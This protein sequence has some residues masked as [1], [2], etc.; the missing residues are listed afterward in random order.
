[1]VNLDESRLLESIRA[2]NAVRLE[3]EIVELAERYGR[4]LTPQ[5][6]QPWELLEAPRFDLLAEARQQH[7]EACFACAVTFNHQPALATLAA[8]AAAEAAQWEPAKM[9]PVAV[10][11][12]AAAAGAPVP[13]KRRSFR[14]ILRVPLWA[15]KRA[16]SRPAKPQP[17]RKATPAVD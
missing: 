17:A 3:P 5:C 16:F 8:Q 9:S 7:V 13:E 14:D 15:V 1:M 10:A 6:I 4:E 2:A 11:A 12:A